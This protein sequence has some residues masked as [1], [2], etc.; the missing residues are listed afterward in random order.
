MK[1][2]IAQLVKRQQN[3][4]INTKIML[5][6]VYYVQRLRKLTLNYSVCRIAKCPSCSIYREQFVI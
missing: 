2:P 1:K 3:K 5:T 6:R 4:I